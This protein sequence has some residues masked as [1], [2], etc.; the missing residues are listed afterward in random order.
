MFKGKTYVYLMNDLNKARSLDLCDE[1]PFECS[2]H[3][4]K[5]KCV[6]DPSPRHVSFTSRVV[7]IVYVLC[8]ICIHLIYFCVRRILINK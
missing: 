6:N 3:K 1:H 5:V 2:Q 4:N 7:F 8:D